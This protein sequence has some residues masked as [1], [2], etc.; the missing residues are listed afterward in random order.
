LPAASVP[1]FADDSV[2]DVLNGLI[3]K[4]SE[5]AKAGMSNGEVAALFADR[6]SSPSIRRPKL[7]VACMARMRQPLSLTAQ[8]HHICCDAQS[9]GKTM[10]KIIRSTGIGEFFN[11]M[12][13]AINAAA[14]LE[15]GRR[16]NARD[17]RRLGID[18]MRFNNVR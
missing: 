11:M 9:E 2:H 16:P 4:Y 10:G 17:L 15:T 6:S 7:C 8:R 13:S 1:A 5:E 14:A 3:K 18:P 12:G